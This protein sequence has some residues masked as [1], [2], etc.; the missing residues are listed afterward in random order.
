MTTP[1]TQPAEA[2]PGRR[3]FQFS[4]RALF[5]LTCGTA[6]FFSLARTLGYVDAVV[7]LAGIVVAVGVMEYPRRVRPVT[8]ILLTLVT[9]MLLWA[10]LRQTGWQAALNEVPPGG[11][12]PLARSMFYRGW[13]LYPFATCPVHGMRFD[14]SEVGVYWILALNGLVFVSVLIAVRGVGEFCFRRRGRPIVETSPAVPPPDSDPPPA[15]STSGPR[16]E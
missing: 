7:I 2:K 3:P 9:G 16:V 8:A 11:L 14:A 10:N 1:E 5:G 15:G 13:P 4:L 6:A 12:D